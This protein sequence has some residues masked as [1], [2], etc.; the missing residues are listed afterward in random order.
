M[1]LLHV[2]LKAIGLAIP[3]CAVQREY[4][5]LRKHKVLEF[6]N[7]NDLPARL[8]GGRPLHADESYCV[9]CSHTKTVNEVAC[10]QNTGSAET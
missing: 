3:G 5:H 7:A 6:L 4:Y 9:V 2:R 10:D 8:Y 1:L